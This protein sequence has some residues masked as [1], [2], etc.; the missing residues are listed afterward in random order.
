MEVV[1]SSVGNAISSMHLQRSCTGRGRQLFI[2]VFGC[3]QVAPADVSRMLVALAG[4][5]T[6]PST[7][8]RDTSQNQKHCSGSGDACSHAPEACASPVDDSAAGIHV[9]VPTSAG[10]TSLVWCAGRLC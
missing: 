7:Q 4:L 1:T 3:V 9:S 6:R 8:V 2:V 5:T 10:P